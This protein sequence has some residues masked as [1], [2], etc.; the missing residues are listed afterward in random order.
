MSADCRGLLEDENAIFLEE[1]SVRAPQGKKN[2]AYQG[3]KSNVLL[4]F[5]FIDPR[6]AIIS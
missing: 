5:Q 6:S 2:P 4:N 3:I 1:G